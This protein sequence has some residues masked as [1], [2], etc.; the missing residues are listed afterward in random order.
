[1][2][3]N[4]T[5]ISTAPAMSQA[6]I[7][8]LVADSVSAALEAQAATMANAENTNRNTGQKET[9]VARKCSYKEFMS[10]Q[11]FNFKGWHGSSVVVVTVGWR[12]WRVAESEYGDRVDPVVRTTFGFDRKN[13]PEKFSGGAAAGVVA[14][15]PAGGW[16]SA[17]GWWPDNG[18]ERVV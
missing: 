5:S 17:E 1:M 3:P 9:H 15:N 7:R 2:A 11:P 13:P 12:W 10:C 8:K 4:R 14:G 18:G 16:G 6:A